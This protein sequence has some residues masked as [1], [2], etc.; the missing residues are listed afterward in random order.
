MGFKGI[1]MRA[2]PENH[3]IHDPRG[4]LVDIGLLYFS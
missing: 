1:C 4:I 3:A 2:L